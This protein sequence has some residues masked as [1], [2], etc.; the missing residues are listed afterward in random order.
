MPV[1]GEH[2]RG[3]GDA[4]RASEARLR[5]ILDTAVDAF[6]TINEHG[7]VEAFNPA[8]ERLF[9]SAAGGV[10][11]RSV[12][13]PSPPPYAEEHDDYLRRYLATGERRIIGIGRAVVARR[14]DGGTF[15][16]DLAVGEA[17]IDG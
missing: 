3:V 13:G 10:T 9:G 7:T 4:L 1:G 14:K 8:A 6:I 5:A 11:A 12:S 2:E 16:I 17:V 15:P